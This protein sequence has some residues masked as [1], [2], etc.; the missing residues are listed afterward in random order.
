M[1]ASSLTDVGVCGKF[2]WDIYLQHHSTEDV[3]AGV[4]FFA[5]AFA[6]PMQRRPWTIAVMIACT[7]SYYALNPDM[8]AVP[9]AINSAGIVL[10]MGLRLYDVQSPA[11]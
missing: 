2:C 8:I 11:T 5:A 9:F 4:L 3:I 10:G 1:L 6:L 7:I